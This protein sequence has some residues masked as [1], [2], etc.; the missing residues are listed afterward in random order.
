MRYF[1]SL[2][3][4]PEYRIE[5]YKRIRDDGGLDA[6]RDT[7]T[8]FVKLLRQ[9]DPNGD[10]VIAGA[11]AVHVDLPGFLSRQIPSF[12]VTGVKEGDPRAAWAMAKF[13][14]CFFGDLQRV[15]SPTASVALDA[16]L[17]PVSATPRRW[18]LR[19]GL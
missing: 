19:P 15:Y 8:L 9:D 13:V 16:M 10:P 3:G 14:A 7:S 18:P 6:W 17:R 5:G 1:L 12:E 4:H 11:G 2:K